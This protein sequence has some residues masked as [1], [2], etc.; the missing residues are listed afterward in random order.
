M[1]YCNPPPGLSPQQLQAFWRSFPFFP[2]KKLFETSTGAEM[3]TSHPSLAASG[4]IAVQFADDEDDEEDDEGKSG[5]G[6]AK[7]KPQ[8]SAG[9]SKLEEKKRSATAVAGSAV[10]PVASSNFAAAV[11]SN[12]SGAS[13]A[14]APASSTAAVDSKLAAAA[15]DDVDGPKPVDVSLNKNRKA[16]KPVGGELRSTS[17]VFAA[18]IA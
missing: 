18:L 5:A 11:A 12:S 8:Q 15:A 17:G 4:A 13:S 14:S 1:L 2:P 10:K 6:A 3:P 7:K 9:A 16:R